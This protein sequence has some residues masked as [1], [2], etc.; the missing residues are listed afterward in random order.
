M[1]SID[2]DYV[3]GVVKQIID[4]VFSH[5]KKRLN[6]IKNNLIEENYALTGSRLG[7][8]HQ[9]VFHTRADPKKIPPI[10]RL[11]IDPSLSDRAT[12]YV[13][14]SSE[15]NRDVVRIWR[16]LLS[17]MRPL[18]TIQDV[19]DALP[20]IV[21]EFCPE[22][23]SNLSRTRPEGWHVA[24][25]QFPTLTYEDAVNMIRFYLTNKVLY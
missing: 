6:E 17:Q 4:E 22:E 3:P 16:I 18:K 7:F 20:E 2:K 19:R 24:G 15:I 14:D 13:E 12:V 8:L 21:R 10:Y 11:T 23:I 25:Q 5:E 9:G 1:T